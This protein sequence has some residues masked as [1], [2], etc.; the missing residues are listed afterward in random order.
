MNYEQTSGET[1]EYAVITTIK[2]PTK[3]QLDAA[4]KARGEYVSGHEEGNGFGPGST[5]GE[6]GEDGASASGE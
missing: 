4:R 5:G 1:N 3:E 6:S 2:Q